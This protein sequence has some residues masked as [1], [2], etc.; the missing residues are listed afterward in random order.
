MAR[1]VRPR[2]IWSV[3][4]RGN[5]RVTEAACLALSGNVQDS[6]RQMAVCCGEMGSSGGFCVGK[7]LAVSA[8]YNRLLISRSLVRSQPGSP[9]HHVDRCLCGVFARL[10][11]GW[12][13]RVS[14][15]CSPSALGEFLDRFA[16][17]TLIVPVTP[18]ASP[19]VPRYDGATPG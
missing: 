10:D 3:A 17:L 18:F 9:T 14:F 5:S 2:P 8:P 1:T 11:K 7:C 4:P 12:T 15:S 16:R 6:S 19:P 13:I